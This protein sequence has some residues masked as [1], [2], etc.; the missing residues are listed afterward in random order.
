MSTATENQN[1]EAWVIAVIAS[2]TILGTCLV[3]WFAW[4]CIIGRKLRTHPEDHPWSEQVMRPTLRG[5][6]E[7]W[8]ED[9]AKRKASGVATPAFM[10]LGLRIE[11][12]VVCTHGGSRV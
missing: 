6:T 8:N 7:R 1:L 5:E 10:P 12:E 2:V 9:Q 4:W 3:V 11:S